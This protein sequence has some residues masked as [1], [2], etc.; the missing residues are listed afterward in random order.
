M[1][2]VYQTRTI[3]WNREASSLED[4]E[5]T[6]IATYMLNEPAFWIQLE[7]GQARTYTFEYEGR[8]VLAVV[9]CLSP[10]DDIQLQILTVQYM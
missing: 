1:L 8:Q 5:M 10:L 2:S 9:D 4:V 3:Q 6:S 7:I